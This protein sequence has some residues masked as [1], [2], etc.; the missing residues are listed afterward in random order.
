MEKIEQKLCKK[1]GNKKIAQKIAEKSNTSI[2]YAG[3]AIQILSH[4]G[5]RDPHTTATPVPGILD[6]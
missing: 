6:P 4:P 5:I 2:I 3:M 1:L